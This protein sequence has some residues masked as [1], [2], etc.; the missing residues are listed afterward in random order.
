[1]DITWVSRGR[2]IARAN[3]RT[4]RVGGEWLLEHNPDFMIYAR[5]VTCWDDGTAIT[6]E[7][8]AKILDEVVDVAAEQG[9]K[10]E[11]SWDELDMEGFLERLRIEED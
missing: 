5:T 1:V 2:V 7:E 10:F 8:R 6:E 9:W 11:I 4:L 3:D